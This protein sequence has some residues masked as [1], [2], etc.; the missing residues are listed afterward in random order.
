[1]GSHTKLRALMEIYQE[2]A[3]SRG[4]HPRFGEGIG[5]CRTF[6]VFPNGTP[7]D[8]VRAKIRRSVELY[9]E[10]VWRGWYEQFGFMEAAASTTRRAPPSRSP[11]STS[12]TG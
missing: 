9:E 3:A 7:E 12:R 5:V 2:G 8:E 10:P 6:Y 4:R 1:M 11:A